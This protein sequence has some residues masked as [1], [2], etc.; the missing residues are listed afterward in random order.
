MSTQAQAQFVIEASLYDGQSAVPKRI[1]VTID[2]QYQLLKGPGLH[3]PLGDIREVPDQAGGDIMV[4]RL[5]DDPLTRLVLTDRS[6]APH[7]PNRHRR[8]P[9]TRRG[10][11]AGW[12]V[13]AVA[14]VALIIFV[15]VPRMA[16]QLALF[17]P[18]EGE[19]ALG[20]VTLDQ[21]RSALDQTGLDPVP[22]CETTRGTAAL[23]KME[24][25]L[26]ENLDLAT[27]L[28]VHVLDHEMVNAFA[29]PGGNIVFFRGL[30]EKAG[31]PEELASVFAH[32]IGHV[33]SRDP[34][35]HAL[36]S[37]GSIGVL[38]LLF[39]DFAGGTIVLFLAE[40]LIDAQYSQQAEAEADIFA[41]DALLAADLPPD[42]L[43]VMF[44][45]FRDMGGDAEG[46][47][48]HFLS[49]PSLGDRIQAA[50]DATPEGLTARPLLSGVEWEALK[51]ICR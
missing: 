29:L 25:R 51:A 31:S 15:L 34:T 41:H 30:L 32:E 7:L 17:I 33:V 19:A 26:T 18:P 42:A 48:A 2:A 24:R 1:P 43:A 14:S 46:F 6:I 27:P 45:R 47:V 10:R 16:D 49:H 4:L 21:I 5:R 28:S 44:A 50:R 3:W 8:A 13:A 39:G 9:V 11:L 23:T 40:R 20:R 35:R 12:A 22:F 37:A 38:G 36:R